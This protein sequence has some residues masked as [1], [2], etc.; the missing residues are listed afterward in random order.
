MTVDETLKQRNKYYGD[1]KET[2]RIAQ[3]I[4]AALRNSPNWELLDDVK[5]EALEMDATKTARILNGNPEHH[6]SWHDKIGYMRLVEKEL[7]P[8]LFS[9]DPERN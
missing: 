6:D 8:T 1:F 5:R 3:N 4:K 2:C 7:E 9:K